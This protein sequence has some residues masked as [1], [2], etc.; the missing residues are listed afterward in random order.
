MLKEL[1]RRKTAGLVSESVICSAPGNIVAGG[2]AEHPTQEADL[3][4][5]AQQIET[6]DARW[7]FGGFSCNLDKWGFKK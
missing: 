1:L 4:I 6:N 2:A 5:D 3:S 7:W